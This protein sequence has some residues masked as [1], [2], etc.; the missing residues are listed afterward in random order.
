VLCEG[1]GAAREVAESVTHVAVDWTGKMLGSKQRIGGRSLPTNELDC[2]EN[3]AAH[4]APWVRAN[5]SLIGKD[6]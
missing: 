3:S 1:R 2:R 5:N 4:I 6:N